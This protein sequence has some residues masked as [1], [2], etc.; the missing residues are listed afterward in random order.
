MKL[1]QYKG[2]SLISK[3]I[4]FQTRSLYSHSAL[5]LDDGR[6]IEAWHKGGVRLLE[7][8]DE[9]HTKGTEIDV[10]KLPS[11][12]NT[13]E[14]EKFLFSQLG[15]PYDF[16]SVFRFVSHT[17]APDNGKWFCSELVLSAVLAGGVTLQHIRH[18]Q[19]SPRDVGMSPL[20][21][22]LETRTCGE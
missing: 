16:S 17:P 10:Y 13:R 18:S 14:A 12:L 21:T 20:A 4:R 6:V 22:Y 2:I 7:S 11:M 8:W 3:I 19:A 9:G 5:E 15:E 1:L